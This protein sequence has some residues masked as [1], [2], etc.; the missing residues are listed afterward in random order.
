MED[1]AAK[2]EALTSSE[3]PIERNTEG[4]K[5]CSILEIDCFTSPISLSKLST[6]SSSSCLS[7]SS[8]GGGV[9]EAFIAFHPLPLKYLRLPL[10]DHRSCRE[11]GA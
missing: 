9:P 8:A 6:F 4:L 5:Y 2:F 11:E 1:K 10:S 7:S 3:S